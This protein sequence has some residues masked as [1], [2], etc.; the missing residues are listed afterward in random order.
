MSKKLLLL[1]SCLVFLVLFSENKVLAAGPL[2]LTTKD[3]SLWKIKP[4]DSA[5]GSMRLLKKAYKQLDFDRVEDGYI[6]GDPTPQ[7]A[8]FLEIYTDSKG[9]VTGIDYEHFKEKNK[10]LKFVTS[11][12]LKVGSS[13]QT[14]YKK[15][16]KHPKVKYDKD[17]GNHYIFLTYPISLKDTKQTGTLTIKTRYG[18]KGKKSTAKV[19]AFEYK[20]KSIAASPLKLTKKFNLYNQPSARKAVGKVSPQTVYVTEKRTDGWYKILTSKGQKW[21]K[22]E[23]Y[24]VFTSLNSMQKAYNK[25]FDL[26]SKKLKT[27]DLRINISNIERAEDNKF[28]I[29]FNEPIPGTYVYGKTNKDGTVRFLA[30]QRESYGSTAAQTI[31]FKVIIDSLGDNSNSIFNQFLEERYKRNNN[32]SFSSDYEKYHAFTKKRLYQN[33]V[34]NDGTD[35]LRVYNLKGYQSAQY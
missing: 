3:L 34:W 18:I 21:I 24:S 19:Y 6:T 13:I 22:T 33:I 25:H 30:I 1:V 31:A 27:D 8:Y 29:E 5:S 2:T 15:Y 12:G 32:I 16:G 10:G 23:I 28:Y 17:P 9:L 26:L 11:K 4:N 14:V 20:V 7:M 35:I